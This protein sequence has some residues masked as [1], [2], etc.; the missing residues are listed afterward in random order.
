MAVPWAWA[1][2]TPFKWTKQVASHFGGTRQGLAISWPGHIKEPGAIRTQFHHVID[3]VPTIL[4]A[5]GIQTP[6]EVNGIKQKPIEG[7][8]MLYTLDSANA[9]APSKRDTQYF[10]MVG[11]RAI[12]HDGSIASTTPPSPPWELG[13]GAMPPLDQYKWE[14]YNITEDYSQYNDLAA[15]N[16][17]KMRG[18]AGAIPPRRGGEV[19]VLPLDNPAS[20]ALAYAASECGSPG[21]PFSPAQVTIPTFPSETLPAFWTRTTPSPRR[22]R[23]PTAARGEFS[24]P[25]AAASVV[26]CGLYLSRSFNWWFHERFFRRVG[27]GVFVLGLLLIWLGQYRRWSSGKMR[28]GYGF[29]RSSACLAY[30]SCLLPESRESV[31]GTPCSFTTCWIWSVSNGRVVRSARAEQD[32]VFEFKYDG[33]GPGKGGTGVL[34]VNGKEV[35]RKTIE[36]TIPLLMSIDETFD[37]GVDTRTPVDDFEYQVPFR[38][39]GRSTS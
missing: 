26:S 16:P 7:V 17:E 9:N 12:Y 13:T 2:D 23:S 21:E 20:W 14:L 36:H 32:V 22:S 39:S 6:D 18:A 31:E 1:F 3:I 24:R 27:L 38:F 11:N 33:P 19:P 15:S 4:V 29:L 35:D 28:I 8:S 5:A 37:V 10:E 30:L 34:S 25:W